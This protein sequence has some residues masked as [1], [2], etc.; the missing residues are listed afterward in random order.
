M[1]LVRKSE[2][3]KCNKIILNISF[4]LYFVI[5]AVKLIFFLNNK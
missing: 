1:K 4:V 2:K 5:N 3:E